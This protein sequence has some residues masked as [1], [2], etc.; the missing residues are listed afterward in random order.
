MGSSSS[1][2]NQRPAKKAR[3]E[4]GSGKHVGTYTNASEFILES[5]SLQR[6][7]RAFI[8]NHFRAMSRDGET[9]LQLNLGKIKGSNF[10]VFL[11][12]ERSGDYVDS[13]LSI[14]P[15]DSSV[16]ISQAPPEYAN[17]EV[18]RKLKN[19]ITICELGLH[20]YKSKDFEAVLQ[21]KD[22]R[23]KNYIGKANACYVLLISKLNSKA[24][25]NTNPPPVSVSALKKTLCLTT[26]CLGL[27]LRKFRKCSLV[28]IVIDRKELFNA[29][30]YPLG[31]EIDRNVGKIL[32]RIGFSMFNMAG[33]DTSRATQESFDESKDVTG[34]A[35]MSN[36]LKSC[37]YSSISED[38]AGPAKKVEQKTVYKKT[39]EFIINGND[40]LTD[41]RSKMNTSFN[42]WSSVEN[43]KVEL[44]LTLG[45]VKN[46]GRDLRLNIRIHNNDLTLQRGGVKFG[47]HI[48]VVKTENEESAL[49]EK[50]ASAVDALQT[51]FVKGLIFLS[52]NNPFQEK[53]RMPDIWVKEGA[54]TCMMIIKSISSPLFHSINEN[55]ESLHPEHI[56]L[57]KSVLKKT[58]CLTLLATSIFSKGTK[59]KTKCS[60]IGTVLRVSEVITGWSKNKKLAVSG[61][62]AAAKQALLKEIGE[63]VL[64]LRKHGTDDDYY[65]RSFDNLLTQCG[66][67]K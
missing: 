1:T 15:V 18:G 42:G 61:N 33:S 36:M 12:M 53:Y 3:T 21:K 46:S 4:G 57:F 32:G 20:F 59:P 39:P 55:G 7:V 14:A 17:I 8:E 51:T 45:H 9:E 49:D 22:T 31:T 62:A 63:S 13:R 11:R 19:S 34:G 29:K 28:S 23:Y 64:G 35:I 43:K 40:N 2:T 25:D 48:K 38:I 24:F 41:I 10:N 65:L 52:E 26:I 67:Q 56:P 54:P 44:S 37:G 50:V 66:Y 27:F 47:G 60:K 6:E 16:D 30:K 58:F 5:D